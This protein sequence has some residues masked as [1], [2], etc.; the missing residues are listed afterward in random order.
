ML[1]KWISSTLVNLREV[2][3]SDFAM[4]L[5]QGPP[6]VH[7]G[8]LRAAR[9]KVRTQAGSDGPNVGGGLRLRKVGEKAWRINGCDFYM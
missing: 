1:E 2:K 7:V 9:V 5:Y 6:P 3:L 4:P 8:S